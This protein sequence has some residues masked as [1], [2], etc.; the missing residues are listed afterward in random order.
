MNSVDAIREVKHLATF[1]KEL[2]I[3]PTALDLWRLSMALVLRISDC[4]NITLDSAKEAASIGQLSIRETKTKKVRI[5]SVSDNAKA[6]LASA[7]KRADANGWSYLFESASRNKKAVKP[8]SRITAYNWFK[9]AAS[10]MNYQHGTSYQIGTHSAR[11]TAGYLMRKSGVDLAVITF[12][13]FR[14]SSP[15]I[16]ARYLGLTD[17]DATD[18]LHSLGAILNGIV[19]IGDAHLQEELLKG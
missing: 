13:V 18:A 12:K 1:E 4:L 17:D 14:H 8:L 7:I 2:A 11:K 3:N 16:T 10:M 9:E 15:D 19:P 6:S 5:I